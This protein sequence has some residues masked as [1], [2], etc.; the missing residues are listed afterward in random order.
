MTEKLTPPCSPFPTK[1]APWAARTPGDNCGRPTKF[2]PFR[3]SSRTWVP[4]MTSPTRADVVCTCTVSGCTTTFSLS[5]P[6]CMVTF[7]SVLEETCTSTLLT[8]ASLKLG[9]LGMHNVRAAGKLWDRIRT[10]ACRSSDVI[11]IRAGVDCG[12]FH[13]WNRGAGSVGYGADNRSVI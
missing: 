2:S 12:H 1:F 10:R 9:G 5:A 8:T 7:T 4:L 11:A 13:A 3:G 6:T